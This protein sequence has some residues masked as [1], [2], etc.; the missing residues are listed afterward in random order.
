MLS[1]RKITWEY[2]QQTHIE[3]MNFLDRILY[4]KDFTKKNIR[5]FRK[6]YFLKLKKTKKYRLVET[7]PELDCKTENLFSSTGRLNLINKPNLYLANE[8]TFETLEG[9]SPD[10]NIWMMHNC[11]IYSKSSSVSGSSMV[12]NHT[13]FKML[14]KHDF[15]NPLGQNID[16][17]LSKN[18]TFNL[19]KKSNDNTELTHIHLL[20]E[21]SGN[22]YH[23]L[24]ETMPKF[25]KI[26]EMINKRIELKKQKYILLLDYDLPSQFHEI[27]QL[28]ST[29]D[30]DIRIVERFES[31]EC[32]KII[33]CTDFWT[34][35]DNTR[36]KPNIIE[37]FFVDRYAVS[38]IKKN[39]PK[40][41]L[42]HLNPTRKIYFERQINRARSL[43]NTQEVKEFLINEGFEVIYT[44]K[45]TF[46]EQVRLL[47][48]AKIIIGTS[49]AV[50][51]NIIFMQPETHAIIF[52]PKTVASNYYVFQPMADVSEV[53][54]IH[55]LTN[56]ASVNDSIHASAS[57]NIDV[58]RNALKSLQD[59]K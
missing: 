48:E 13:Y 2:W 50:F 32:K 27:L 15:K 40:I 21:H 9:I 14:P 16:S 37:E 46:M 39:L 53:N 4:L 3:K 34:S 52:S 55:I 24:F 20:N 41:Y 49:G 30:Y 25:I 8:N 36:F 18:L 58:V 22:Y 38:L 1:R 56:N 57:I 6:I 31:V 35:V 45:L 12:Y 11:S 23:W 5:I 47:N 10:I 54:L 33:Y 51:S 42:S 26:C 29:I 7:I 19:T 44:E 17:Y 43:I 28:Y 59:Y